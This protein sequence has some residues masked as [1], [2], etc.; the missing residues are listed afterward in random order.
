MRRNRR[1]RSHRRGRRRRLPLMPPHRQRIDQDTAPVDPD[2][3]TGIRRRRRRRCAAL[4]RAVATHRPPLHARRR[5]SSSRGDV[6]TRLALPTASERSQAVPTRRQRRRPGD[7]EKG[8]DTAVSTN[9]ERSGRDTR[10]AMPSDRVCDAGADVTP[11]PSN[12]P[13]VLD[14]EAI[15]PRDPPSR[16]LFGRPNAGASVAFSISAVRW[17]VD[18]AAL[19]PSPSLSSAPRPLRRCP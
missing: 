10:M 18:P 5:R 3:A 1:R 9:S 17:L 13:S 16:C 19:E 12:A 14:G 4:G 11:R 8:F 6:Q 7:C 15:R 2:P